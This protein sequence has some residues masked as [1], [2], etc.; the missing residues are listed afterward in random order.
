M[1]VVCV[2][3]ECTCKHDNVHSCMDTCGRTF[4]IPVASKTSGSASSSNS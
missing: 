3:V 4:N 2:F 1:H